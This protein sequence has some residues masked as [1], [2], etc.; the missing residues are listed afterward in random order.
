M[1]LIKSGRVDPKVQ[2][3]E[4]LLDVCC[5]EHDTQAVMRIHNLD[6]AGPEELYKSLIFAGAGH[7]VRST[8]V[9]AGAI[10][11]AKV[12]DYVLRVRSENRWPKG[13][14]SARGGL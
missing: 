14:M 2:A 6:R 7:K 1:A 12:L 3:L 8:W 10:A 5:S 11:D 13:W 4:E 9:A